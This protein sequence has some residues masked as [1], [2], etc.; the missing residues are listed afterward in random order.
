[1]G[2]AEV[3][4]VSSATEKR[5]LIRRSPIDRSQPVRHTIQGAFAL[6]NAWLGVQFY[7]WVRYFERGAPDGRF[8]VRPAP[9]AGRPSPAS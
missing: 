3:P 1:M 7:L 5:K 4:Q 6:L 2:A 9:R 8:R